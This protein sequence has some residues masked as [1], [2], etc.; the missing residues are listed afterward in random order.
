M[1]AACRY[2]QFGF[3]LAFL[4]ALPAQAA[5]ADGDFTQLSLQELMSIEV[6]SASRRAEE[7]SDIVAAV[8]VVTAEDIA[9]SSATT[10][11]ELLAT[12]PG[13]NVA[14]INASA[15]AVSARDF[16]GRFAN[17]LL[18]MI[19]GRTIYTPLFSGVFWER[20]DIILDDIE[21]IEIIRGPGA[22]VWGANAVN[23]IINIITKNAS[24]TQGTEVGVRAGTDERIASLRQGGALGERFNY[25]IFAKWREHDSLNILPGVSGLDDWWS[26]TAGFRVDSADMEQDAFRFDGGLSF[27]GY[28]DM[29]SVPIY[30]PPFVTISPTRTKAMSLHLSGDWTHSVSSRSFFETKAYYKYS[31]FND[32][33]LSDRRHVFDLDAQHTW[34]VTPTETFVCGGALRYS[35]DEIDNGPSITLIDPKETTSLYSAFAQLTSEM[36]NY[37]RS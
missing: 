6:V 32:L 9:V 24:E 26:V 35:W 18:V 23:G 1:A 13:L 4:C 5:A 34:S 30:T 17:K 33:R 37:R 22:S 16:N 10:I 21:R 29:S 19:D 20:D 28:G 3:A 7:L 27:S 15:W 11:P 8:Y 25:R 2:P 31:D 36:L 14:R 12:V